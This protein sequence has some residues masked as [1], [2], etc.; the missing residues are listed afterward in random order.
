MHLQE[1]AAKIGKKKQKQKQKEILNRSNIL[2]GTENPA[3]WRF[4]KKSF[5]LFKLENMT[6]Q[7]RHT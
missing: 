6:C 1:H 7:N 5:Y 3:K 4:I 2:R